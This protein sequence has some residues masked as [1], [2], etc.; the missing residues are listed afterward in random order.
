MYLRFIFSVPGYMRRKDNGQDG[1]VLL[2]QNLENRETNFLA[3]AK[4]SIYSNPKSPYLPLLR[5]AGCEY[6]DL[7]QMADSDGLEATLRKLHRSGVFVRFEEFKGREPM[8]RS[9]QEIR[10][11]PD[12]FNNP[13]LK[14]HFETSSSGSTGV[15]TRSPK[16]LQHKSLRSPIS[17]AIKEAQG[18]I[19][20]P[21]ARVTG[22][23]PFGMGPPGAL[24]G[25]RR[26]HVPERW[27][28][29]VVDPPRRPE[30]RYLMAHHYLM[31]MARLNGI[32]LP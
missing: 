18:L 2:E 10:F 22:V 6:G 30:L 21:T 24:S 7:K 5:Q 17:M 9:G 27:F 28:V 11:R 8:V 12:D 31:I 29:P 3:L 16:D 13:F 20:L 4:R 32:P 14:N 1:K 26:G 25:G 19:G 15:R 23:L